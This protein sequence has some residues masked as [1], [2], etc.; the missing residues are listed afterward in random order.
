MARSGGEGPE[1]RHGDEEEVEGVTEGNG[2]A[3]DASDEAV[4][5]HPVEGGE[6]EVEGADDL[7]NQ[8][9]R[10]LRAAA[11]VGE[12]LLRGEGREEAQSEHK[13]GARDH[14]KPGLQG[15]IPLDVS[16]KHS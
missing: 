3:V 16:E 15:G 2:A 13:G 10:R 1:Q 5:G 7:D 11:D 8:D 4:F 6:A 9:Q 14:E 12:K